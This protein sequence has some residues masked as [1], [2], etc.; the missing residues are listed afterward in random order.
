MSTQLQAA[1]VQTPVRRLRPPSRPR[2]RVSDLVAVGG[3]ILAVTVGL[4]WQHGGLD[5][6]LAGGTSTLLAIGQLSGLIAA[7]AAM[8]AIVLT[9]RPRFI[10]GRLGL[11]QVLAAHRWFGIVTVLTVVLHAVVDTWAW[12]ASTGTS[13]IA[14]LTDL[15]ANQAWMVA[16][17]VGTVLF[18]II[19]LSSWRR[20]RQRMAYETWYFVH[21][22]GYLA[23]LLGFGH[24]LTLGSDIVGD[25]LAFWWWTGLA[26]VVAWIVLY[27]RI[28][29]VVRSLN[30]RFY[31]TAVSREAQG[32]GSVHVSGPGLR[33]LRAQGGQFFM[34]RPL[35]RGLWWQA[36]PISVSAA[37]TTAGLRFTVKDLGDG[38]QGMLALRPGTRVLLEGPY[39]TFTADRAN[40]SKVLL[41][42]GGVGIT[43]LRAILEDCHPQQEPIVVVRVRHESELPHRIEL[44]RL[45]ASRNGRLHVLVGRRE[46]LAANDPFSPS[47]L[48][49]NVPDLAYRQAFVCGP[50]SLES[51]VIRGLRKAGMPTSS[52]HV[53]SFGC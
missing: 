15:L 22:L 44:E 27:A 35:A 46:W 42:G 52:I 32:I 53:E 18:V 2:T 9:S 48:L 14:A 45:V 12:A 51:A 43:P 16:A 49:A 34:L 10:E 26:V 28:G 40:D 37:P 1:P 20:I 50:A 33:G 6:L 29:V 38:S 17:L 47:A 7:L 24:Q 4:W 30:R 25:Q 21:L 39:G 23:V 11:D 5:L 31:V 3:F 13:F 41:I 19:G 36:H 8:G